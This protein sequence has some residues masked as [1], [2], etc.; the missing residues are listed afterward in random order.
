MKNIIPDIFCTAPIVYA[1]RDTYQIMVPVSDECVMW[2]EVG[3]C[4]YYDDSNG[5]LRSDVTTHRMIIPMADLD[6]AGK[7]KVC[8]RRIIERKPYFTDAGEI[9]EYESVFRPVR[10]SPI[11]IYHIADAHNQVEKPVAA[12]SYFGDKLDLLVLNGDIPNHSGKIEYLTTIHEIA[13]RITGGEIPVVFSRGNHDTRGIHAEKIADHTPTDNGSSYFTFRLGQLWGIVLDCGEDKPDGNP[14]YGH[15]ICCE[16]FRQRETEY[17]RSVIEDA[18]KEYE[19]EGVENKVVI[20]H[21][22]FTQ[23]PSPPFNIE[24]DT[25]TLWAELLREH[26]KPQLMI[27]G[28]VHKCYISPVGGP[29]DH[30]G[31]PCTLVA[32]S[33]PVKD[34][35]FWGGAFTLYADRCNVKFTSSDGE[36]GENVDIIF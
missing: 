17:L 14:E 6:R 7:Y 9:E 31:Q 11:H 5:I 35:P 24:I 8:F 4:C 1:V 29:R 10:S 22:P 20:V 28:H 33:M 18:V 36:V 3:G 27:C 23:T 2:A 15:T 32:A 25:Y 26:I 19:S 30:K 21:V 12:G 13:A 16:N 34:G